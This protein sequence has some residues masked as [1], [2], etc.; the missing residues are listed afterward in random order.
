MPLLRDEK[1]QPGK[2]RRPTSG[3]IRTAKDSNEI[4]RVPRRTEPL[5]RPSTD[6]DPNA[7]HFTV[8]NIGAGGMLYLKP[9]RMPPTNY[10][11]RPATPPRTS[12]GGENMRMEEVGE[13]QGNMSGSWTPRLQ[14]AKTGAYDH[15][16]PMPPSSLANAPPRRRPRSRSFSTVSDRIRYPTADAN[17]FQLLVNGRDTEQRPKSS[18]DLSGGFLD[19]HIPH[20]RLGTP[21]FSD[22]G[23]AYLHS[24]M[25]TATTT[26]DMRSSVF[27]R[28]DYDKLFPA[29]PGGPRGS[30]A[31]TRS[32]PSPYLHPFAARYS[33]TASRTPPT[34]SPALPSSQ[35][36]TIT[37]GMF[38]KVEANPDDPSIVRYHATSGKIT[39]ATPARLIAQITSPLFLDYELLSDFFLTF[40]S[41]MPCQDLLEYLLARMKWA[42]GTTTDAGRIVRVRTFVAL[43]HWILNYFADDFVMDARIRQRF[44]D[45]VN[46]LV[47]DLRRRADHG[48][49][50]MNIVGEMK[51]C[52]RRTCA[53][54]FPVTDALDTLPEADIFPG[55]EQSSEG[56]AASAASLPLALHP[57]TS[58]ADFRRVSAPLQIPAEPGL[59]GLTD[60]ATGNEST[61]QSP[62]PEI[63][64]LM[65]TASI[66]TSPMSEQSLQVLSCSVPFLRH[67]RPSE[68]AG[69]RAGT[70][71]PVGLQ[72]NPPLSGKPSKP[73]HQHKR[74]GSFSDALRD[75]RAPLPSNQGPPADLHSLAANTFTGGLVRGLLLQP[76]PA[77]VTLL[78][79]ISPG[80]D[81]RGVRFGGIEENYFADR[82]GQNLGVKRLVGDVRRALSSRKGR[83]ES[84]VPSS[85]RSMNSSDSRSSAN[86]VPV[87]H[88]RPSH[89]SAWQQLRGPPRVDMLGAQIGDS[90]KEAFRDADLPDPADEEAH[91]Q[92]VVDRQRQRESDVPPDGLNL[93]PS[94][95]TLDRWNSRVTIG[96][97][98]ILIVDDTGG[99]GLP[100]T[101]RA[102]PSVS[103]M[104][105]AMAPQPLFRKPEE[106]FRDVQQHQ[107]GPGQRTLRQSALYA[108]ERI[109]RRP[110]SGIPIH[111]LLAVPEAWMSDEAA[112]EDG[113]LSPTARAAARKSSSAQPSGLH[114]LRRRPGGD[115]KAA[116]HVHELE[117]LPRPDTLGSFSTMS[118]SQG[119]SAVQSRE[120][121]GTHFSGQDFANWK[122]PTHVTSHRGKNSLGLLDW[123]SS[124][125]NLR[126]CFQAEVSN[127]ADLPDKS[128]V[129]GIE[130]TLMKL[131]GKASTP[132]DSTLT[133]N[134]HK[135]PPPARQTVGH[136]PLRVTNLSISADGS[137]SVEG[138]RVLS[139][140][141]ETQGASIYRISGS[142][143]TN[144]YRFQSVGS[145]EPYGRSEAQDSAAPVLP[146][147]SKADDFAMHGLEN[148]SSSNKAYV[149]VAERATPGDDVK[150]RTTKS[151]GAPRSGTSQGSFLLDDN[152]SLSDISTEIADQS[153]E[154]GG[155][156]SFF[157]DDTVDDDDVLPQS[158]RAPPT[159]PSTVGAPQ[160]NS[161]ERG[162]G[163]ANMPNEAAPHL[164]EAQSAA[165]LLSPNYD[166]SRAHQQPPEAD[167]RRI[168][169]APGAQPAVHLPFLLAFESETVAEQLTIIEKDALDEV[170]WKDL[171][172]LNWQQSPPHARNWVEYLKS[173]DCS[174]VDIVVARFNLV[175]KWVVSECLL[176]EAPSERAR[177]I[178]K[179]VHIA[180]HCR[181]FRNYASM[182]QITLGLL[183][184]DL[185]RL[186]MT[187]ALVAPAEKQMLDRL[188]KL[189]QPV[190]NF[191]HLRQE[192]ETSTVDSGCIPFIG[193]YTHD[194]MFNA[195]KPSRVDPTPMG[196]EP[197]VN[198]ERYQTAAIIVKSLLRLI[199]ASSKYIFH[200]HPEVLSRCLWLAA[201][202][203]SEI[204]SRSKTLER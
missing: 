152:E 40:R 179:F 192:M 31:T 114:Q 135:L 118:R 88:A 110:S 198:F 153:E 109:Y 156:R 4:I 97:R 151:D 147:S 117:P 10:V 137:T 146:K 131:E 121:S 35:H 7:R 149:F 15:A 172:G 150:D 83:H 95:S 144:D 138:D 195:Q 9:S 189:C 102:L 87:E 190:R 8:A 17:D 74:S 72:R 105:S 12:D 140:R 44:C 160:E 91:Q 165:K 170:D 43:R 169:T 104:S 28:A 196:K 187:W 93:S 175:V 171:I 130:D 24:S 132:T 27:S 73:S 1:T 48:G 75:G 180:T 46:D 69:E 120:L 158:F 56:F 2:L 68:T 115:L 191:S 145:S 178:T 143:A 167:L 34:H 177:C 84:P 18:V 36:G 124:P 71:R 20:Y 41:F 64:R 103:S 14:A 174:G 60:V 125:P 194:L 26:D 141:T 128:H 112:V 16:I 188:E 197:L 201:L 39:A 182:Y 38:D 163:S 162:I 65:R 53:M 61:V 32:T 166:R 119:T 106:A 77:K 159:P 184:A 199:E 6:D 70:A 55:C 5:G 155:V 59:E 123:D 168:K 157:F 66:P 67:L 94:R 96:D 203:D 134:D 54:Y 90:Y 13:R 173:D 202:D 111:D 45:L 99:H 108:G 161:P 76:S 78:I 25:Y 62:G 52:W 129:G 204:S 42:M 148:P 33:S 116:D 139:P 127:L 98:S 113:N 185:A 89:S 183:S 79:P 164:K 86:L 51:K 142:D 23:T 126:P 37:P 154:D 21:R 82:S 100:M 63:G 136:G 80:L 186:H 50:D 19:L 181:R 29:P 57:K 92:L 122:M 101:S 85:H 30:G 81:S 22:R 200:P 176:T 133:A 11:Q 58:K 49:S 193:L 107:A 3:K 47:H